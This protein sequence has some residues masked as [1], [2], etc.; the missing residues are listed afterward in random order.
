MLRHEKESFSNCRSQSDSS[1][2]SIS[3]SGVNKVSKAIQAIERQI[4]P[5]TRPAVL[6]RAASGLTAEWQQHGPVTL[7]GL[8]AQKLRFAFA[9][10]SFCE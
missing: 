10:K 2:M 8:A 9:E 7:S 6:Q 1:L 4:I 5:G 3:S